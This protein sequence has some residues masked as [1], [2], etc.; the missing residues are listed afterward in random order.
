MHATFW[1]TSSKIKRAKQLNDMLIKLRARCTTESPKIPE[2]YNHPNMRAQVK[3]IVPWMH[4]SSV[5]N[6]PWDENRNYIIEYS[7]I[8]R[9]NVCDDLKEIS[10]PGGTLLLAPPAWNNFMWWF[11]WATITVNLGMFSSPRCWYAC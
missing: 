1:K 3:I 10:T 7:F 11:F 2:T 4:N 6:S 5:H 8:Q 9:N